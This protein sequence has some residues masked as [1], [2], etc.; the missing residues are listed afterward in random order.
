MI[1]GNRIMTTPYNGPNIGFSMNEG[2]PAEWLMADGWWTLRLGEP[3]Y[4]PERVRSRR[5]II[6]RRPAGQA[7]NLLQARRNRYQG[8]GAI[9]PDFVA[10]GCTQ[11]LRFADVLLFRPV[12]QGTGLVIDS[13]S[14]PAGVVILFEKTATRLTA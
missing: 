2:Y 3:L 9:G 5:R 1:V 10:P 11:A 6:Q 7:Q 12:R 4:Y 13:R 14:V 8:G